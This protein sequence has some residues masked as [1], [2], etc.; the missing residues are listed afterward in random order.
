MDRYH[1]VA[2]RILRG[3]KI[4]Q[5][6]WYT[7]PVKVRKRIERASILAPKVVD[8]IIYDH[9]I[10]DDSIVNKRRGWISLNLHAALVDAM[11]IRDGLVGEPAPYRYPSELGYGP[12]MDG[13]ELWDA[14]F[15]KGDEIII[16]DDDD[17]VRF[18][19][20]GEI[21]DAWFV[22]KPRGGQSGYIRWDNVRF[23]CH[24]GFPVRK[25]MGDWRSVQKLRGRTSA[26]KVR[27]ALIAEFGDERYKSAADELAQ[28]IA[29]N[30]AYIIE[31]LTDK[32]NEGKALDVRYVRRPTRTV[33]GDP[34]MIDEV[35]TV[36]VN[37][38]RTIYEPVGYELDY[39]E[40]LAMCSGDGACA[41]LWDTPSIIGI[42]VAA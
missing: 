10:D 29:S 23:A 27:S 19:V 1:R 24:E 40:C 31:K 38:G 30:V 11:R 9:T 5:D 13:W 6:S 7:E 17:R 25:I 18:G 39:E 28:H 16:I 41:L 42:E 33:F 21:T 37:P 4:D 20:I 12:S 8:K 32:E 22:L 34:F 35:A 36:L 2:D 15:R 3:L 14:M 26:A